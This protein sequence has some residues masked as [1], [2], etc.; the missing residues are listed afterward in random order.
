MKSTACSVASDIPTKVSLFE[1]AGA[2]LEQ[3]RPSASETTSLECHNMTGE[4][5]VCLGTRRGL[6]LTLCIQSCGGEQGAEGA[7]PGTRRM[8]LA[9]GDGGIEERSRGERLP[10]FMWRSRVQDEGHMT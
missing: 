4:G 6:R 1:I 10:L 5:W 7:G 8:R 2:Y 3:T 9:R